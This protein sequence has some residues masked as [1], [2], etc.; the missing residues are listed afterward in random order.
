M[1][2]SFINFRRVLFARLTLLPIFVALSLMLA[3][4][5]SYPVDSKIAMSFCVLLIWFISMAANVDR[6]LDEFAENNILIFVICLGVLAGTASILF[7]SMFMAL[8]LACS[9]YFSSYIGELI[10]FVW[11]GFAVVGYIAHPIK[12]QLKSIVNFNKLKY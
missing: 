4:N 9:S 11:T 2:Y 6:I 5:F 12:N 3:V 1:S 7:K 10:L 8:I